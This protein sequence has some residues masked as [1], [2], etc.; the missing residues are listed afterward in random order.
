MINDSLLYIWRN[1]RNSIM[2]RYFTGLKTNPSRRPAARGIQVAARARISR[3]LALITTGFILA[4]QPACM[5][6]HSKPKTP[7]A[8][9]VAVRIALLPFN[10]PA[11]NS[12]LRWVS[13]AAPLVMAK[14]IENMASF[15][16]V[17]VW[18]SY[19][20]TLESLGN[21]RSITPEIAAYVAERVGAK[22]A[23]NGELAPAK[24]GVWMRL[25]FIPAKT[26]LVPYRYEK[27]MRLDAM[28]ANAYE[29]FSQLSDYLVLRPLPKLTGKGIKASSMRELAEALDREY[30]WYVTADPGKSEKLASG[31]VKTDSQFA[32]LLFDPILYPAVASVAAKPKS[33]EL[34]PL[35]VP[36][37]ERQATGDAT[38]PAPATP[39]PT[40]AAPPPPEA[41]AP[42]QEKPRQ[43]P[44][45]TTQPTQPQVGEEKVPAQPA[46]AATPAPAA[47]AVIPQPGPPRKSVP[48]TAKRPENE[49]LHSG[50]P[51]SASQSAK[52][53]PAKSS[54][55][56]AAA[57]DNATAAPSAE[58]AFQIQVY[59]TQ[60]KHDADA[61]ATSLAKAGYSPKVD[62]VDLKEKGTWFR[63]RLQGF[64]TRE[65]AK[66]AGEKLVADKLISQYWII[67]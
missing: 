45:E 11:E 51:P 8:P 29:A 10:I 47:P 40:Q 44:A 16:V 64:K 66:E 19:P 23:T 5:F 18:Q 35:S 17:P 59:S 6:R 24:D 52:T 67:P 27:V 39:Q 55:T 48:S 25:D 56:G 7:Q 43:V 33:M 36:K 34:K 38:P 21:G 1:G 54:D 31:L 41:P 50:I 22:W 42:T 3:R 15:E 26:T 46:T 61:R 60:S 13:M 4:F 32:R 9:A 62:Q 2:L 28:G 30:G 37:P 63:I 53:A 12:D 58:G 20:V 49:P 57:K 14:T 65:A